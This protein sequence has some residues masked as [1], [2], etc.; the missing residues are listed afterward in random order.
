MVGTG[1]FT[2][3]GFQVIGIKSV[4]ALLFLWLTGGLIALCGALTYGELAVRLP[5]S[6][7][8]YNYL[9]KIYHPALGF[10]SGWVSATVGFAAPMA[11][12]A[13]SFGK[14]FSKVVPGANELQLA[15]GLII[16]LSLINISSFKFG[17]SFQTFFTILN[18][19]LIITITIA[20]MKLA[21]HTHFH[22]STTSKDFS[23]IA[24]LSFATSLV[25]VSY[26][27][28]GWNSATYIAGEIN[29]PSINLPKALFLGS[30]IVTLLYISLN[31]VFLYAVPTDDLA[32][33][34]EVAD[35][36]AMAILGTE[37]AMIINTVISIGLI[38]S[39][40]SMMI[41]GPRVT[42]IIGEDFPFFNFLAKTN[43]QGSPILAISWQAFIALVLIFTSKFEE[44]L[45]YIGLTLS[46]FTTL[47]VAGIF[48]LRY[49]DQKNDT[50]HHGYKTW[51]YPITPII[52]IFLE[53]WMIYNICTNPDQLK[54]SLLGLVTVLSGLIV[55][56]IIRSNQKV[57]TKNESV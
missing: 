6:G 8:E 27:Y 16:F 39:V 50:L 2:S 17:S 12:A 15:A 21:N 53:L 25:Y 54:T 14:Y 44:V 49:R 38:A 52:F 9:S 37:G 45:A 32:G 56:I 18:I 31:F 1:V 20:G 36:A 51:G 48:V 55:Y 47:T 46:L 4:F 22:F 40:N 34:L 10:L 42:K 3:L 28:S 5:R 11:I 23:D 35:V 7:G 41:A 30:L 19:L 26:A 33:K 24:S 43:N 57:T 29:K 13:I